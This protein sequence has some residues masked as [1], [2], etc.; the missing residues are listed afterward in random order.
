MIR[1]LSVKTV[2][3]VTSWSHMPRALFLALFYLLVSSV[4]VYPFPADNAPSDWWR[5]RI[6]RREYLKFW[7]S[8]GR[9]ALA[10]IGIERQ[11]P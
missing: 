9:V 11:I 2:V 3:L 8:L 1:N 5:E 6:F 7:G 10:T 4:K